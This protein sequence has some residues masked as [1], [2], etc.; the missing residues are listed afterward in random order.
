[1]FSPWISMAPTGY[2]SKMTSSARRRRRRHV[3]GYMY[4]DSRP[5]SVRPRA[6]VWRPAPVPALVVPACVMTS[7]CMV[8]RRCLRSTR[9]AE[10]LVTPPT[11]SSTIMAPPGLR[12]HAMDAMGT[13]CGG[14]D[15]TVRPSGLDG[16][17]CSCA[18]GGDVR[19]S[20][21]NATDSDN[22]CGGSVG[23]V[24]PFTSD[25]MDTMCSGVVGGDRPFSS[26]Y[27][28]TMC[29]G[30]A[31]AVRPC[32]STAAPLGL[33]RSSIADASARVRPFSANTFHIDDDLDWIYELQPK[34]YIF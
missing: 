10:S 28:D 32:L 34:I 18:L 13:M 17:L 12:C 7:S 26:G 24:R 20:Y 33:A 4:G 21:G 3:L 6:L 15:G 9:C 31:G 25:D 1:M 23:A 11:L 30:V 27:M 2:C 8:A 19:P 16:M 22:M 5:C 14:V 29:G